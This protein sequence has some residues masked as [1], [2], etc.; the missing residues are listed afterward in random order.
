MI[1]QYQDYIASMIEWLMNMAQLVEWEL[2]EETEI[3]GVSLPQ[4]HFVLH[5]SHMT[6]P[7]IKPGPLWWEAAEYEVLKASLNKLRI[8]QFYH[9][10]PQ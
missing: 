3:L 7:G 6:W 5:K 10:Q 1:C 4:C 2:T 8:T 9:F